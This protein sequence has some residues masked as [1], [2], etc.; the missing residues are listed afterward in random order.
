M[1]ILEISG[2]SKSFP[3]HL[4]LKRVQILHEISF[5]VE[6]GEVFGLL[7]ANGAGKTTTLKSVVGLLRPE[8][9]SV[10]LFGLPVTDPRARQRLGYLPE[11]PY[12][13]DYLTGYEFLDFYARLCGLEAG[14]RRERIQTLIRRVGLEGCC[15]RP[16]RKF[17]KGMV[18]RVGVA[19]AL[20]QDPDLVIL[21]EPMSGLDP[22][23]RRDVRDII[24]ELKRGGKTVL[25]SS[26]ILADAEMICDRVAILRQGRVAAC[27][28]LEQLLGQ[29]VRFWE[30]TVAGID[31]ASLSVPHQQVWQRNECVLLRV[32]DPAQVEALVREVPR[33]GGRLLALVPHRQTLEDVFLSEVGEP[34]S[35]RLPAARLNQV[36][37]PRS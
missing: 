29:Q 8:R 35:G 14:A 34:R 31:P 11:N 18:Q 12:F 5:S 4:F 19:Q 9:G 23:G 10:R 13:Y 26:H 20:L 27:G 16:L 37:E 24:L 33:L 7:G 25:F 17:S 6:P 28:R 21:D 15:E 22:I 30:A 3:T 1:S 36:P 2:L 32:H